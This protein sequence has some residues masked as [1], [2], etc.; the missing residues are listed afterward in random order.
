[1]FVDKGR[2]M[3]ETMS[4]GGRVWWVREGCIWVRWLSY[5]I[6]AT[7]SHFT[8]FPNI[9]RLRSVLFAQ[10]FLLMFCFSL[11][12]TWLFA[13]VRPNP[14]SLPPPTHE[15]TH[16][17]SYIVISFSF[18]RLCSDYEEMCEMSSTN[19]IYCAQGCLLWWET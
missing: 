5:L 15:R 4:K 6:I 17:P 16:P 13:I 19:W 7:L 1:M 11:A 2:D 9:D 18:L 14:I 10:K 12:F 3:F 8:L